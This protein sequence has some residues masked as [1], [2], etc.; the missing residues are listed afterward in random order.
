MAL[1][2][3][4]CTLPYR[5]PV[6]HPDQRAGAHRPMQP[7][8]RTWQR[9]PDLATSSVQGGLHLVAVLGHAAKGHAHVQFVVELFAF[10]DVGFRNL[11]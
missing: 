10:G 4:S 8:W 3:A 7:V 5:V 6:G 9:L 1:A 2:S 11:Q